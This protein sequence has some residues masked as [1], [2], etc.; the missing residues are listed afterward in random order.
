MGGACEWQIGAAE[1]RGASPYLG[2]T[3]GEIRDPGFVGTA[4]EGVIE[5]RWFQFLEPRAREVATREFFESYHHP[6]T[7]MATA[8]TTTTIVTA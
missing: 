7:A 6:S 1:S 4:F 5:P 8:N 3:S 2:T